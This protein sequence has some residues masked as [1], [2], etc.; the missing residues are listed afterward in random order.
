MNQ[1][2]LRQIGGVLRLEL[3]RTAF[4]R[5]GWWIYLL[6]L[7]PVGIMVLHWL[8]EL[9]SRGGRHSIGDDSV[10]FAAVFLFFFLR[11][12][13]FFGCMGIFTNLFRGEMLQKTMHYYFLTP[14]RRELLVAGKYLA[15]LIV[16]L[17]LF[18]GSTA[19]SF[20][21]IGRHA[22]AAW[23]DYLTHGPGMSQLTS[24]CLV[25]ALACIGYGAVFLMCGLLFRNP[26]I[27]AATVWVWEGI[28]PFLPSLLKKVSVIFY[29]KNLCPV[30]VPVPPPFSLMVIN[31]EP[32]PMWLAIPG[33]LALA[34]LLLIYTA[35]SARQAEINYSE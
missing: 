16:A 24:Y 31:T 6:A 3:K 28:N 21:I 22:G 9:N 27:P 32:T 2:W 13:I 11:G 5:R 20:L 14:V 33:L 17:V 7:A 30:E 34:L 12:A 19:L 10:A 8:F 18:V 1:L 29:L 26:L 15:G 35:I 23:T 25:A 4:S